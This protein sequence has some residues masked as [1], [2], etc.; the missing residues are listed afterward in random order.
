M[1]LL[2]SELYWYF[3]CRNARQ[4]YT[5]TYYTAMHDRHAL[6]THINYFTQEN[7]KICI[8]WHITTEFHIRM[9]STEIS[10]STEM[11]VASFLPCTIVEKRFVHDILAGVWLDQTILSS[12]AFLCGY[13]IFGPVLNCS[14]SFNLHIKSYYFHIRCLEIDVNK[15]AFDLLSIDN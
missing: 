13:S 6:H 8:K 12:P 11:R 7:V 5:E 10:L 15:K 9:R 4:Q 3:C 2:L 1:L 14:V